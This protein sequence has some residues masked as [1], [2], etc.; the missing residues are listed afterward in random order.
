MSLQ[1]EWQYVSRVV[2][3]AGSY[4]Q[5]IEDALRK[6]FLPALLD[7]TVDNDLR[8]LLGQRAKNAGIG[9]PNPVETAAH[10]YMTSKA[11]CDILSHSLWVMAPLDLDQ[12]QKCV[13][14][15]RKMARAMKDMDEEVA[16]EKRVK[17]LGQTEE[18][19][20]TRAK[21][22][23][24]W[25]TAYPS[26]LNGTELSADEFRDNLR[27]RFG[28][29]PVGLPSHCDG[30]GAKFTVEHGL[31]CKKGGLVS[32]RHDDVADEWGYLC[33][34]ALKPSAVD[35]EPKIYN[36]GLL[37][38]DLREQSAAAA[39]P[40]QLAAHATTPTRA[41]GLAEAAAVVNTQVDTTLEHETDNKRGD[42]GVHGFLERGHMCVFDM[43]IMDTECRTT[44]NLSP[45][46]AL[47]RHEKEKK[48][49]YL[50]PCR[51][52]R[53][54]FTPMVYSVDGMAG[55]EARAAE[56]RL[57]AILAAKWERPYSQMVGY[58]RARMQVAVVRCNT[59]LLRGSRER[60][61]P[62]RPAI[63]DGAAMAA[64]QTWNQ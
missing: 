2:H 49:K 32:V 47:A 43:R 61:K 24:A 25:L 8:K 57:G 40:N 33:G 36:G 50:E 4:F 53:R 64:W 28:F 41:Q 15:A 38:G 42:K 22:S 35:H 63:T 17:V 39:T 19:R 14:Q 10:Q 60:R 59:L 46:K 34:L 29:E 44:R 48:K 27:L 55:P 31:Q 12:H 51:L 52:R 20:L 56:R 11:C 6:D 54:H 5:P 23:G 9:I 1:Q 3:N 26:A 7:V 13:A 30:C 16:L 62:P 21:E 58:V 37:P 18:R 45:V